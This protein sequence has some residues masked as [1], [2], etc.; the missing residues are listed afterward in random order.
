MVS[1]GKLKEFLKEQQAEILFQI[2]CTEQQILENSPSKSSFVEK[3][4]MDLLR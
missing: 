4:F 2:K 3:S 1:P